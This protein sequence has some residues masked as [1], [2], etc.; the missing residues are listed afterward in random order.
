MV[1]LEKFL[2]MLH[3]RASGESSTSNLLQCSKTGRLT[4][5]CLLIVLMLKGEKKTSVI[6]KWKTML[7]SQI[8]NER[9]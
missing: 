6:Q 7:E 5:G 2:N 9:F 3:S 4:H 1:T 8:T